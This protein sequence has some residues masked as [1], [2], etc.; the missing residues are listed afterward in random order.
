MSGATGP[1]RELTHEEVA[2]ALDWID[3][4]LGVDAAIEFELR[5]AAE[6]GLAAR[7]EALARMDQRMGRQRLS[8]PPR[9]R[10]GRWLALAAAAALIATLTI[11]RLQGPREPAF[12]V[13]L[14]PSHALAE[15]WIHG[16]P[17]L[18]GQCAPGIAMSRGENPTVLAP[19][20]FLRRAALAESQ[21]IDE[22]LGS[23]AKELE[24]GWFVVPLEL[25]EPAS[26]LLFAWGE[27]GAPQRL[28]PTSEA[29]PLQL[30]AGR[31]LLPG[32]RA[33]G[34]EDGAAV[35]YQPGF[36]IPRGAGRWVVLVAVRPGELGAGELRRLED[37]LATQE[38]G[39]GQAHLEEQGFAVRRL[40]VREPR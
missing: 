18:A 19:G 11:P 37:L 27:S 3:G 10:W 36:L 2:T 22:A 17:A 14:A 15:D 1:E 30:P 35:R 9:A 33:V 5:L 29:A 31:S 21:V 8:A 28:F 24:A 34:S 39:P 16:A 32:P 25:A 13:A 4:N 23:G 6:P 26:V 40:I 38:Q 20:E 7:V 12:E